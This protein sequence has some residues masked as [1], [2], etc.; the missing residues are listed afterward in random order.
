[1][2]MR[3]GVGLDGVAFA[4]WVKLP[5]L[6]G[7]ACSAWLLYRIM[8]PRGRL[9]AAATLA[10]FAWCLDSILVSGYHGN[11][12]CLYAFF[13]L[14]SAWLLDEKARPFAGGLA[15]AAALNV[16]LIPII[17]VPLFASRFREWRSLARYAAGLSIAAV[18]FVPV[19]IGAGAS[20][21]RNAIAYNS[22]IDYWGVQCLLLHSLSNPK[23]G[24]ATSWL[25]SFYTAFGRYFVLGLP[26]VVSAVSFRTDRWSRYQLGA[27]GFGIFLVLAPGFGVQYTASVVPLLFAASPA[28]GALFGLVAGLFV[29]VVYF[30][31]VTAGPPWFSQFEERFTMPSHLVGLLAWWVMLEYVVRELTQ[32]RGRHCHAASRLRLGNGA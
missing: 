17:L 14:L 10:A 1:L 31:F 18:P 29:G 5:G 21:W 28:W 32:P 7:E 22:K 23:L 26:L 9:R 13:C 24:A 20:F 27:I 3:L 11:T 2:W 16:K 19:L 4:F 6:I 12:D 25:Q 30:T 8:S 15:L